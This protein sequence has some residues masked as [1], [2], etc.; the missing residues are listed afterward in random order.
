MVGVSAAAGL[1][2]LALVRRNRF[3][4]ARMSA[5]LAVSAIV[6]GWAFAQRPRFLPGLTVAQ[7]AAGHATLVAVVVAVA[8]GGLVVLPSLA[9]L[10]TLLLRG[11]LEPAPAPAQ[12]EA[13][14]RKAGGHGHMA[15]AAVAV[16]TAV[17]GT[18]ALVLADGAAAHGLGVA[19]VFVCAVST[20]VLATTGG[21]ES[22]L[23]G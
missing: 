16:A 23:T 1:V 3:G 13:S 2:T 6:A 11:A 7:A 21:D 14:M 17:A 10:F 9:L 19:C 18:G 4:P 22:D 12:P 20:F 5:A 8:A 15:L